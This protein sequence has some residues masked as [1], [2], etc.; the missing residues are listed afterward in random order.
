MILK[1]EKNLSTVL[2]TEQKYTERLKEL[3]EGGNEVHK[4][5]ERFAEISSI[6]EELKKIDMLKADITKNI[7]ILR[8][9]KENTVLSIDKIMFDNTVMLDSI[10]KN[11]SKLKDYS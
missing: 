3:E 1:L 7:L 2:S 10:F 4:D 8:E 9:K 5:V 11:F 6:R